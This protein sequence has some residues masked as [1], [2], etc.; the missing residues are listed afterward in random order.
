M[1]SST[2]VN[3][4]VTMEDLTEK[5]GYADK[6]LANYVIGYYFNIDKFNYDVE[7]A[8]YVDGGLVPL[9]VKANDDGKSL[10]YV[11]VA[12]VKSA[13]SAL[14]EAGKLTAEQ[15]ENAM[16]RIAIVP[17]VQDKDKMVDYAVTRDINID[18][19]EFT[20]K[21]EAE[22]STF[23]N[24]Y[25]NDD[26]KIYY[27]YDKTGN[28]VGNN[29]IVASDNAS[30]GYYVDNMYNLGSSISFIIY[31]YDD[32]ESCDLYF[33][34]ANALDQDLTIGSGADEWYIDF[35]VNDGGRADYT[36]FK[37]VSGTTT[38]TEFMI[39]KIQLNKGWNK[40]TISIGN[41]VN[42]WN[43]GE[44]RSY[45]PVVDYMRIGGTD[46]T[47]CWYP[48]DNSPVETEEVGDAD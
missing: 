25:Y 6:D 46:T 5:A 21:F 39:K 37:V 10:I 19:I 16:L 35:F 41:Q 1:E 24:Y 28:N 42:E 40:I 13:I 44:P 18:G 33:A 27:Y 36:S 47:I 14:I 4:N 22:N 48:T 3:G 45:A 32:I 29:I 11:S 20:Y 15:A 31:A 8:L 38:F 7:V 17:S 30:D 9:N 34:L 2:G 12:D 43:E 26:N 23:D